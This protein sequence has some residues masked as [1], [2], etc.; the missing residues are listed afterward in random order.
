V[1]DSVRPPDNVPSWVQV[2]PLMRRNNGT[3]LHGQS[4]GFLGSSHNPLLVDQDLTPG[5]VQLDAVT[6]DSEVPQVRIVARR[7]LLE[8]VDDQRRELDRQGEVRSFDKFQNRALDLLTSDTTARAFRLADEP[9]AV[10]DSYGRTQFGQCCLLARRLAEAGVPLISVHFCRTPVGS[11]DT[12]SR[13]FGQM[14]EHLCPVF[15]QAFAALVADLDARQLL[16]QTLVWVN[17]EFGR[18]PKINSS[19]GR[20]H[21]PWV[22]SLVFAGGGTARGVIYGASDNMAAQPATQAHD[23][24]DVA[25]TVYHLLGVP[26]DTLIYDQLNRPQ[27]VVIGEKINALI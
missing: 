11:W 17:A 3:I 7:N 14:K 21:W 26:R 4:A 9:P 24:K 1:L 12:H 18:T 6:P 16:D 19:S 23:P 22:Y 2:G 27:H 10:R 15:D 20:D 13:H 25:A 8:Q 5:R